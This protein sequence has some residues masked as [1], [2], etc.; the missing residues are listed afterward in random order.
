MSKAEAKSEF[1]ALLVEQVEQ[2]VWVEA[3]AGVAQLVGV[4]VEVPLVAH[5]GVLGW[6]ELHPHHPRQQKVAVVGVV[7]GAV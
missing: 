2:V 3:P 7:S 6:V 4:E 5:W 1:L